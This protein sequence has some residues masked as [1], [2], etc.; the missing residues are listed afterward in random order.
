MVFS[1]VHRLVPNPEASSIKWWQQMQRSSAKHRQSSGNPAKERKKGVKEPAGSRTPQE[2][3]QNQQTWTHGCSLR[4][5][6]QSGSLHWS[7]LGPLHI[8]Y[9]CV[10]WC[11]C[12]TR[13]RGS[14]A[15]SDKFACFQETCPPTGSP[16]PALI[17]GEVSS[18]T[19]AWYAVFGC[20][21][22]ETLF[23]GKWRKSRWRKWGEGTERRGRRGN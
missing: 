10:T 15:V 20:P 16:H 5:N 23:E 7:N 6:H 8:C 17:W 1:Y 2:N 9:S 14:E 18:L 13:N 21:Y 4:L 22:W 3:P 12:G 19:T 11:F